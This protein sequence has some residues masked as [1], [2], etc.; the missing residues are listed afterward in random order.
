MAALGWNLFK[1]G[2]TALALPEVP[3]DVALW[4]LERLPVGRGRYTDMRLLLLR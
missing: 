4:L 2:R 1:K 3:P